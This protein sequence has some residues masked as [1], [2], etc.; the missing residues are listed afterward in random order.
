[1]M[2]IKH[3]ITFFFLHQALK[4]TELVENYFHILKYVDGASNKANKC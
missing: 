3:I 2:V 4:L 1:M